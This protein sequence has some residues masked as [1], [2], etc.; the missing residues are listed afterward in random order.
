MAAVECTTAAYCNT[1][2]KITWALFTSTLMHIGSIEKKSAEKN[3]QKSHK[4]TLLDAKQVI[5]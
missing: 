4:L 5:F 1:D 2:K 3:P